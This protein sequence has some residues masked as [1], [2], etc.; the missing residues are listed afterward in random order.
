VVKDSLSVVLPSG[1]LYVQPVVKTFTI[2]LNDD[3]YTFTA[4]R[5]GVKRLNVEPGAFLRENFL[6]WQPQLKEITAT[7]PEWLT[8][9]AAQTCYIYATAEFDNHNTLYKKIA[10]F[11]AGKAYTVN[12][13]VEYIAALMGQRPAKYDVYVVATDEPSGPRMSNV[14]QYIVV[15]N[16][17]NEQVF[18]FQ[19]SLGGID[20]IRCTGEAKHTPEY[21]ASTALMNDTED[22]YY[23]EK[24]DLRAQNT[25]WLSKAS[26]AWLHDFFTSKQRY[27]HED[28]TLQ[29]VVIDE[30]TAETSTTEDLI[31]FEFTYRPAVASQHLNIKRSP[32]KSYSIW[33]DFVNT[34]VL[35]PLSPHVIFPGD[36][37]IYNVQKIGG[38][39]WTTDNHS[40][41]VYADGSPI[42]MW[43]DGQTSQVK[44][45]PDASHP[46]Y[47][48]YYSGF[49]T[50]KNNAAAQGW[51]IP[52]K[53]DFEK[54][55]H[56]CPV[57]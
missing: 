48:N 57:K 38:I 22:T 46:E 3:S 16:A 1:A 47:G 28:D 25:G 23:I 10:T 32:Q 15:E 35:A 40:A 33:D 6:T 44:V 45:I 30:V 50:E 26:A 11:T 9:Y 42:E 36:R 56:W 51:R 52:T 39:W 53:N 18:C 20:A 24:K 34:Y 5:A 17:P 4:I 13:S 41:V 21:T 8:Y 7:Q 2:K 27:K 43:S 37:K 54:L 19:N 12:T 29:P 31:A 14:Q 55:L 49:F